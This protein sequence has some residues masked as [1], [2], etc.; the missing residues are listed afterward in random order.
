SNKCYYQVRINYKHTLSPICVVILGG[1]PSNTTLFLNFQIIQAPRIKSEFTPFLVMPDTISAMR[2]HHCRKFVSSWIGARM[3][4]PNFRRV[5]YQYNL[6]KLQ[7][8]KR[9]LMVSG[10]WEAGNSQTSKVQGSTHFAPSHHT[11][12]SFNL[13]SLDRFRDPTSNSCNLTYRSPKRVIQNLLES[14]RK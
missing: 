5:M 12:P 14:L 4:S 2:F 8:T 11:M 13:S 6:E 9:W 7:E 10:S 1:D 3:W